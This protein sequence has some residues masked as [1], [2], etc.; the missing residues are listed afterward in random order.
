MALVSGEQEPLPLK[1]FLTSTGPHLPIYKSLFG[2]INS[3]L[4]PAMLRRYPSPTPKIL[5]ESLKLVQ[6]SKKRKVKLF[7]GPVTSLRRTTTL[8]LWSV[9]LLPT[10]HRCKLE[11]VTVWAFEKQHSKAKV[12]GCSLARHSL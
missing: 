7:C 12:K 11:K 2:I 10:S 4:S 8:D 9:C 3:C 5:F 1:K 6:V